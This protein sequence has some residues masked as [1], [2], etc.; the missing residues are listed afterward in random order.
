MC[1]PAAI[2][3]YEHEL[4]TGES[5]KDKKEKKVKPNICAYS[6]LPSPLHYGSV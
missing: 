2:F 1:I 4:E 6:G 3:E 5:V